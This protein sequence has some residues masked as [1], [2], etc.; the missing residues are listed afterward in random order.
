MKIRIALAGLATGALALGLLVAPGAATA[1]PVAPAA[2]PRAEKPSGEAFV[3]IDKG[4]AKATEISK[5]SYRIVV[6]R[7]A[8][9][10]WLG[11]VTGKGPRIG[12]YTPKALIAGWSRLGNA[13]PNRATATLTWNNT[14]ADRSI[15]RA[16]TFKAPRVDSKGQLV[17]VAKVEGKL[18]KSLRNFSINVYPTEPSPRSDTDPQYGPLIIIAGLV[19]MQ[20]VLTGENAGRVEWWPITGTRSDACGTVDFDATGVHPIEDIVCAGLIISSQ[21]VDGTESQVD[22]TGTQ[23]NGEMAYGYVDDDASTQGAKP[24][25]GMLIALTAQL[26]L[27]G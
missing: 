21:Q 7:G 14:G 9:I 8:D 27:Y 19:Y 3:R 18:P 20:A 16:V 11:N 23:V 10:G 22:V 17:F 15:V 5:G 2:Q 25:L 4:A 6:P 26:L 12:A 1:A 24:R 13:D